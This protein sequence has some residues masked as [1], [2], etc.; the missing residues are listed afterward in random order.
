MDRHNVDNV[1][2][3]VGRAAVAAAQAPGRMT[4]MA[5]LI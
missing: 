3:P 1:N 2:M 5:R 4:S